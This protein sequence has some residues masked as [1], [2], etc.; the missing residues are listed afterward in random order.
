[1]TALIVGSAPDIKLPLQRDY[2]LVVVANGGAALAHAGGLTLDVLVTTAYLLTAQTPYN[3]FVMAG[4]RGLTVP[5]VIVDEFGAETDEVRLRATGLVYADLKRVSRVLRGML[6]AY[7]VG[8]QNVGNG[9]T[10]A[11]RCSTGVLAACL[12]ASRGATE[13]TVAGFSRMNGHVGNTRQHENGAH[14]AADDA[15][16]SI[17]KQRVKLGTTNPELAKRIGLRYDR[18]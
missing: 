10:E 2:D 17:L 12:A 18:G 9:K 5:E 3:S 7:A 16:M 1:M 11:L 15:V 8:T 4:W 13:I 14:H 6:I